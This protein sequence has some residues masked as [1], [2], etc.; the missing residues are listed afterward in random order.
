MHL[1]YQSDLQEDIHIQLSTYNKV[2][3]QFCS[4]L[5]YYLDKWLDKI[6]I[7]SLSQTPYYS[8][9]LFE[10]AQSNLN[11]LLEYLLNNM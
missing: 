4:S 3:I 10:D 2:S 7:C 1:C 8:S 11:L 9:S 6:S 5:V